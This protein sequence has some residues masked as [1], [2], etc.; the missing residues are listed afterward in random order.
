MI[1][2]S[3][4]TCVNYSRYESESM[5]NHYLLSSSLDLDQYEMITMREYRT[6]SP[7]DLML[8]DK[9]GEGQFGDVHSGFL[10]PSVRL[11]SL[12][13]NSVI[14]KIC[15]W[16]CYL[17]KGRIYSVQLECKPLLAFNSQQAMCH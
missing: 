2:S 10:Y 7:Q 1:K 11:R 8:G 4:L 16:R 15:L 5:I 6:I 3:K 9:I 17:M 13:I 12:F 14:I